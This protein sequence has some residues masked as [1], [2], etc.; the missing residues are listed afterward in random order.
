MTRRSTLTYKDE[1]TGWSVMI[2]VILETGDHLPGGKL[3]VEDQHRRTEL[4]SKKRNGEGDLAEHLE[5]PAVEGGN[6]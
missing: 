1:E 6:S 2:P 3:W 4:R 5:I